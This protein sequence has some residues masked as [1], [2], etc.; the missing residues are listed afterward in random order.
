MVDAKHVDSSTFFRPRYT[1]SRDEAFLAEK[2]PPLNVREVLV[3]GF[4]EKRENRTF[5]TGPGVSSLL[6]GVRFRYSFVRSWW[7]LAA[8]VLIGSIAIALALRHPWEVAPEFESVVCPSAIDAIADHSHDTSRGI[9]VAPPNGCFGPFVVLPDSWQSFTFQAVGDRSDVWLS[10][11][12][13]GQP[14]PSE[15]QVLLSNPTF[16]KLGRRI[17]LQ[18]NGRIVVIA[19]S[20]K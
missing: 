4:T 17:R 10:V 12:P 3:A 19:T 20:V 16:E 1:V 18:S 13:D 14:A 8:L 6:D 11:W 2:Q 5:M 9:E 7:R 15:P